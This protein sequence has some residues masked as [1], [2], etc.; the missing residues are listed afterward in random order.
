MGVRVRSLVCGSMIWLMAASVSSVEAQIIPDGTLGQEN[1]RVIPNLEVNGVGSEVIEGGAIRGANLFHS[2]SEFNIGEGRGAYFSN[3]AGIVNILSRVT[4]KNP[5]HILG[6]LGILGNANLFFLNP[7]GIIFGPNAR[8]DLRG[9][10][11]ATTADSFVFD[12]G[13]EFGASNPQPPLLT[14]NIPVR[15]ERLC[16]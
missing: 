4:G 2:F 1:S 12:S 14:I 13:F 8:L 9:S 11:L 7:N 3:P 16:G 15:H 5:S 10:F 6:T